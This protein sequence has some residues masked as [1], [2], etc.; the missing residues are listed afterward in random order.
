MLVSNAIQQLFVNVILNIV[1]EKEK[2]IKPCRLDKAL[3]EAES[4]VLFETND[5][6]S[7]MESLTDGEMKGIE[8]ADEDIRKGRVYEYSSAEDMFGKIGI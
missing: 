8:E 4:G 3:K 6:D 1:M 5:L 2:Y 7:L